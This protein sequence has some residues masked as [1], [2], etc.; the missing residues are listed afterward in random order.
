MLLC[1]VQSGGRGFEESIE[2]LERL[3][4]ANIAMTLDIY[5]KVRPALDLE[6]AERFARELFAN[7]TGCS[8]A[9]ARVLRWCAWPW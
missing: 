3:G 8:G 1:V 7:R 2:V 9:R 5:S 6:A 4:H